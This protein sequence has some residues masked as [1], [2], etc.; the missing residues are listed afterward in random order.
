MQVEL[1]TS[2][3][4]VHAVTALF[5]LFLAQNCTGRAT[6]VGSLLLL[7]PPHAIY[8]AGETLVIFY[9]ICTRMLCSHVR[10]RLCSTS[11]AVYADGGQL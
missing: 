6:E 2:V 4:E 11:L 10:A 7:P 8:R 3:Q 5:C 9:I 1:M